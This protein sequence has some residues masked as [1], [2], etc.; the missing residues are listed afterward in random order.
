MASS[1]S[2]QGVVR[3]VLLGLCR[4]ANSE[5]RLKS[6]DGPGGCQIAQFTFEAHLS[7][8]NRSDDPSAILSVG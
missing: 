4:V 1:R 7:S 2:G 8:C 5:D 6:V 3:L